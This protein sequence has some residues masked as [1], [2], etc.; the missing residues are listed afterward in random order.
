MPIIDEEGEIDVEIKN[1]D[2]NV[3]FSEKALAFS[4]RICYNK[5]VCIVMGH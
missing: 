3:I 1:S 5:T 4:D 2:G